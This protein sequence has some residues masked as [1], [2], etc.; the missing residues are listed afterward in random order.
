MKTG[1]FTRTGLKESA[2]QAKKRRSGVSRESVQAI[3]VAG[4]KNMNRHAKNPNM[5]PKGKG[6]VYLMLT[7]PSYIDDKHGE[8]CRQE[9]AKRLKRMVRKPT[10]VGAVCLTLPPKGNAPTQQ[11]ID[12]FRN[13]VRK[14][15]YKHKPKV[16]ISSGKAA[17]NWFI[18]D[19]NSKTDIAASR[20]KVILCQ[21]KDHRFWLCP[22]QEHST[23][24]DRLSESKFGSDEWHDCL[25]KDVR[26]A[27]GLLNED[28][29]E[30][31]CAAE[32]DWV[33]YGSAEKLFAK[34]IVIDC[35]DDGLRLFEKQLK[36]MRKHERVA[37]DYETTVPSRPFIKSARALSWAVGTYDRVI[38]IGL[39]HSQCTWSPYQLRRIYK[40]IG[41]FYATGPEVIFHNTEFDLEW[42]LKH[43]GEDVLFSGRWHDTMAQAYVLDVRK[44]GHALDYLCKQHFGVALKS[45]CDMDRTRLDTYRLHDVLT[46]NGVDVMYTDLLFDKQEDLLNEE[47]RWEPYD[48]TMAR[49]P[50]LIVSQARGLPVDNKE[51]EKL[52]KEFEGRVEAACD[53]LQELPE[54]RSYRKRY[55][56]A[57]TP[58]KNQQL[59]QLCVDEGYAERKN[60]SMNE[61]FMIGLDN[62]FGKTV[63]EYRKAAKALSTYVTPYVKRSDS[64]VV[65]GDG[66]I[67]TN[68]KSM[69]TNTGRLSSR[70]PN[71]QNFPKRN[72]DTKRIRG[73]VQAPPGHVI[74]SADYAQIEARVLAMVSGDSVLIDALY[75]DYDIHM[76]W[77]KRLCKE[78][79]RWAKAKYGKG[80]GS[81]LPMGAIRGDIKNQWVFPA[82]YGAGCASISRSL[83]IPQELLEPLFAEFWEQFHQTKEW[84]E[85]ELAHYNRDGF[86]EGATGRRRPAPLS[87][88][89][90]LNGP[91]QGASSD[92]VVDGM[93]R[94]AQ[95]ARLTNKPWLH[96]LLNI[97]DD[98][99]FIIPEKEVKESIK[100]IAW[101]MV[102]TPFAWINAPL[103]VEIEVG[104]SWYDMETVAAFESHKL[105]KKVKRMELAA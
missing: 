40:L 73:I 43:H 4:A 66:M 45:V 100:T 46:Y 18:Y 55:G 69:F 89:E 53:K 26:R 44:G 95:R 6:D 37:C 52:R 16:V 94:L 77:A 68:L 91:V 49:I 58:S 11:Q 12:C 38:S 84:Q 15:I 79:P 96:S 29:P 72:P 56:Q 97:H 27:V 101:E 63:I 5:G 1:L 13:K 34:N 33:L 35:S 54:A 88:N 80:K 92:I 7:A 82:F 74:L 75:H 65:Y 57:L 30:Y 25:K 14:D 62:T 22:V 60:Q 70:G 39:E 85:R 10:R 41:D 51:V 2:K 28:P 98:L 104:P 17:T 20:G 59:G 42:V 102:N 71:M 90:I 9:S 48:L 76:D 19:K 93:V 3:G 99:T 36:K 103:G 8:W 81:D 64:Y 31:T 105:P 23:V 21:I 87:K 50:T 78:H 83:G 61:E 32:K 47:D 24:F 67:H 86:I